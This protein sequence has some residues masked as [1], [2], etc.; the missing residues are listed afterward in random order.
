[1]RIGLGCCQTVF[2]LTPDQRDK[3][4]KALT[5]DNPA[6]KSA[7]KYGRS[8]Y[9]SIPKTLE[10]YEEFSERSSDGERKKVLR[11]PVGVDVF[12]LTKQ[13]RSDPRNTILDTRASVPV[14]YPEFALTLREDQQRAEDAYLSQCGDYGAK[15]LI[16]LPTGKGK[17][18]LA[19]HI[20]MR[21]S[22]KT[23]I[24]VHKDDLVVGWK[25]DIEQCFPGMKVGLI[26]A[27]SRT[28][29]TQ[30]TIATVQTLSRMSAEEL[31]HYTAQF[32]FVVQDECHHIGLNIFNVI[33]QFCSRY[34]LGLTATPKRGDGLT[35]VFDLFLGGLCYKHE[36]TEDDED[37]S[38]VRVRYID[39]PYRYKPF[40][41][42]GQI[43]NYYDFD[44]KDLPDKIQFVEEMSGD[45][46]PRIPFLDLDRIMVSAEQTI[47][48]VCEH[49]I[50]EFVLG[51]SVL[52]M[53][54][55]KEHIRLYYDYLLPALGEEHLMCYYGD[56]KESSQ[57]L[58]ERA[59]NN[60]KLVTL[61]T[62]AKTTEGTN[63][64]QWEVL[65]MV[66]S[67]NNAKNIE[68]A[69]GRIRRRKE[70]KID[71]VRVYVVRYP[72]CYTLR[73][74]ANTYRKTFRELKYNVDDEEKPRGRKAI[75]SR[76]YH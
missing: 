58:M 23:L 14:K 31:S 15:C 1:M 6:Y 59:E 16:Q 11:L 3:V 7:K 10:Y 27:K 75:F 74:H 8:R 48:K 73:G 54:T 4:K 19:L 42:N 56:S 26:K 71:P 28:I 36:I 62:Y 52:V 5:F 57:D 65:F 68:Q 25:K 43:F 49:I 66:S 70:G 20:A 69:T 29:G 72:L 64:K 35:F 17:S 38:Q 60:R 22:Q 46:R 47:D 2:G 18:I 76:G 13:A 53:F 9:I 41:F 34:K 33:G 30:I 45:Q 39:S 21:L 24:L 44:P 67:S 55:Q 61:A 12:S 50:A 32:G 63:V 37:I 51:H 40:V